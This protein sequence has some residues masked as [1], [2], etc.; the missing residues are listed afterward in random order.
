MI[1]ANKEILQ[2]F[3]QSNLQY[4]IP[5]FQR[6]YVWKL[7][8]W[9]IFWEHLENEVDEY[10][11]G[12]NSEHFI[13]TIITKQKQAK[14]LGQNI[15]E[16]IDGQQR[17]TTVALLLKALEITATGE[18][19]N[20]RKQISGYLWIEDSR[21]NRS[22][23]IVHSKN[24]ENYFRLVM[25]AGTIDQL[26]QADHKIALATDFFVAKVKGFSDE[27]RDFYLQV[28]LNKVPI[29]S[30]L[31]SAEDDEQEIFD[32]INS[33]GV[34]LTT[35]ELLKNFVFK[36]N[37][38]K[39][40]YDDF[41]GKVFEEDDESIAFW[42]AN[43]VSGRIVRTNIELLL[44][45]YLIIETGT[46]VKLEKLFK[47][48]KNWLHGKNSEQKLTFLSELKLYAEIYASFPESTELQEFHFGDH[49]KRLFYVIESMEMTTIIPLLLYLG[50]TVKD[51]SELEKMYILLESY[52]LR[53]NVCRLTTKNYNRLV[54]QI[55]RDLGKI[56]CT[57]LGLES[58][59][60]GFQ[61]PTNEFPTDEKFQTAFHN[62]VLTNA[63]SRVV[64]FIIALKH[65]D[66]KLHDVKKLNPNSFSVEHMMPKK[67]EEHWLAPEL[68]DQGKMYRRHQL[69]TLGNLTLVTRNLNSR[70]KNAAWD[71]KKSALKE[72][73]SL[74]ITTG[75]LERPV[76]DEMGIYVRADD[77][78]KTAF[79]IWK[80][81][82][83]V[84][85]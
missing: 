65:C 60:L 24:D 66:T 6:P 85:P 11:A 3:F 8:N 19:A 52:L 13:G 20:L 45:C 7:E 68:D 64:L 18:F 15:V 4:E 27:Q 34:R 33:L 2:S 84:Q 59:L 28:L 21:G 71:T 36:E 10:V 16:L 72:F 1:N 5:F 79:E 26:P 76:W 40:H 9:E 78:V 30:M 25:Q 83:Q 62:S 57:Y 46:E 49:G 81:P 58:V 43:K 75:Y 56:G 73:S 77:L 69:Q 63:Y 67:W 50:K 54:I 23:R 80:G 42:G 48:Y 37:E 53:R 74:Q 44:Y 22:L 29:I 31:L 55:I 47:E 51:K 39:P 14:Q 41:W 12:K 82:T 17:L 32:T 70:M 61:D 38:L 35:G